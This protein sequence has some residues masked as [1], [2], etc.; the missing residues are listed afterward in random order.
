MNVI[1][2]VNGRV[3]PETGDL[4]ETTVTIEDGVIASIGSASRGREVDARGNLVLPGVIDLHGDAFE[5]QIMPRPGVHFPMD[6]ALQDTDAQLVANGIT[7]A[8]H[9][10]TYSWEPGLRGAEN[11]RALKAAIAEARPHLLADT[12]FHLRH[13]THNLPGEEEVADWLQDGSVDLLAFND[14]SDVILDRMLNKGGSTRTETARSGL[15]HEAFMALLHEI[16]E[17]K[18][19]VQASIERLAEI[20]HANGVP[21]ASHDDRTPEVR[22]AYHALHARIAEFPMNTPTAETAV[23]L[24]D[25]VICGA[26][27]VIRGGSHLG[28]EGILAAR[29]VREG[30]CSILVS[31]YYYP[32][33]AQA[34]FRLARDG[35]ARFEEAWRLVSTNPAAA[36]NL[37]DRG[38]I[39]E[40]ARADVVVV[41]PPR[42][43][44]DQS[45]RAMGK[46]LMTL[47]AGRLA[48][49]RMAWAQFG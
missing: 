48:A 7:T 24:G 20:A 19:H 3:L 6:L 10:V 29:E 9:G 22:R 45:A 28:A 36:A 23:E 5:R 30:R 13:E 14:H 42:D 16:V 27:N 18:P 15:S 31:D 11:T 47:V 4:V 8:Y 1:T 21:I 44:A 25:P 39:R 41:E 37:S 26:P 38:S 17:R 49:N 35:D 32:A 33:L 12:R 43:G 2:L 40:G 46:I 34:P